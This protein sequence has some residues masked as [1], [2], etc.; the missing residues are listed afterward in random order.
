MKSR[1]NMFSF[2]RF[3]TRWQVDRQTGRS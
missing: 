1:E 3:V 2:S